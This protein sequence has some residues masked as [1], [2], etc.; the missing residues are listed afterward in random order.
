MLPSWSVVIRNH[1]DNA[2][3]IASHSQVASGTEYES[4]NI[5]S[6]KTEGKMCGKVRVV[7]VDVSAP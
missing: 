7:G 6:R 5:G 2:M 1:T 3:F 4:I